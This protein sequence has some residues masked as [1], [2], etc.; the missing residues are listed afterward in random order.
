MK[1]TCTNCTTQL[2]LDDAKVPAR[3]FT[4]RCPKCQQI[5][6][7]QP[8][9]EQG[10][11]DA[12]AAVGDLPLTTRAQQMNSAPFVQTPR[13][14]SSTAR[15]QSSHAG[16]TDV[17]ALLVELLQ[18]GAGGA[19]PDGRNGANNRRRVL[20]CVG[21]SYCGEVARVLTENRCAV[22]IAEDVQ[23]AME[24]MRQERVDVVV[25][26][27]EF[28][29]SKQGAAQINRELNSMRMPERRRVVFVQLSKSERTGDPHAA[30]LS[31]CNLVVNTSEVDS[32]PLAIEKNVRD[33]NELYRDF[34]KALG[35]AGL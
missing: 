32:L 8:P 31:N 19:E 14:V 25:L 23:Q 11:K 12:V 28:D 10:R 30:F 7:A 6:D 34:N 33:L 4:V 27:Q 2:Q 24:W 17:L 13:P 5:I 22:F 1:I 16:E 35:V 15:E 3:A 21:P 29:I 9:G 18:R 20:V 26:D